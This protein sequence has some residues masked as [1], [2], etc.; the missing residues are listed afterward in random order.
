MRFIFFYIFL[1]NL[2]G[3]LDYNTI[4]CNYSTI[5]Q[6]SEK[7]RGEICYN[8]SGVNIQEIVL[9]VAQVAPFDNKVALKSFTRCGTQIDLKK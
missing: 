7:K 1:I 3:F 5:K 8:D 4:N 9:I 6:G 2:L